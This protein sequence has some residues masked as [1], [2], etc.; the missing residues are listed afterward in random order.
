MVDKTVSY[1]TFV[2][3]LKKTL[4]IDEIIQHMRQCVDK[5]KFGAPGKTAVV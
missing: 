1:W 5:T 3:I 2:I 4:V